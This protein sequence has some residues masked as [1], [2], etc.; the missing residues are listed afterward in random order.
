MHGFF[1]TRGY[2]AR[3]I[4]RQSQS[5]RNE[6][7]PLTITIYPHN[8]VVNSIILKNFK[9]LQKDPETGTIFFSTSTAIPFKLDRNIGNFLVRSVLKTGDQPGSFKCARVRCKTRPLID[10]VHKNFR[11]QAVIKIADRFTCTSAN[12]RSLFVRLIYSCFPRHH[13]PTN[14]VT[15]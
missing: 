8:L 4:D 7:I 14:S 15:L 13:A 12:E 10:N 9:L 5:E 2:R 11:T 6:R 3:Q 1:K